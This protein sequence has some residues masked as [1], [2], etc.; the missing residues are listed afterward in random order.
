MFL[1]GFLAG[2]VPTFF[3]ATE[4]LSNTEK[5]EIETSHYVH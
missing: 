3:I 2:G 4:L 1:C 5:Y